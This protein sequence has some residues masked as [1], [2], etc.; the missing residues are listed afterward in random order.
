MKIIKTKGIVISESN[1]SDFDKMLT[2]LTPNNGKIECIAKGARKTK[3][4]LMAGTQFL[5]FGEYVL[6]KAGDIYSINSCETIELFYNIRTDLDKLNAVVAITKIIRDVTTENQNCYR[7]LQLFLNTLYVI[8]NTEKSIDFTISIFCIRLLSI[9]GFKPIIEECKS[10]KKK[11]NLKFFSIKDSSFKCSNCAKP[12]KSAIEMSD[13]VKD[14]I[15]YI[16]LSEAKKI[17]SFNIPEQAQK[18]IGMISKL[19]LEEKL[20]KK[21]I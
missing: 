13:T 21:Y 14:A 1:V 4:L 19:Y 12:D 11:E 7:I 18:E 2:I 20:E 3:S 10:C 8:A 9:I 6:Y 16:I 17:Y 5:C 15:R